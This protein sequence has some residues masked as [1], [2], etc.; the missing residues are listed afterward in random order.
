L[1]LQAFLQ[2]ILNGGGRVE[3]ES[4]AGRGRIDLCVEYKGES[5]ILEIKLIHSYD[6][7]DA[8]RKEGMEQIRKYRDRINSG[9][10]AY[11]MI[12]DRRPEAKQKS[13]DERL[14]WADED[15]IT[16]LGL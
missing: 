12:F 14:S 4:A 2:R 5:F 9:A 8:I 10:P 16:V 15:G 3:R 7:P 13:W 1:L 11:L 6:T